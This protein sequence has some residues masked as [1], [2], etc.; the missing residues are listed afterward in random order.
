MK[1]D[2]FNLLVFCVAATLLQSCAIFDYD[3]ADVPNATIQGAIVDS[4][5]N[6]I[7]IECNGGGARIRLYDYGFSS[8]PLPI[9]LR[10]KE[11]G[12]FINTKMF[13]STYN[14]VAEGPFVP[15]IQ[16]DEESN[17]I[18]DNSKKNITSREFG[19]LIFEVEPY[20][21]LEWLGEPVVNENGSVT[22]K[23]KIKRGTNNVAYHKPIKDVLLF[24]N[25]VKYVGNSNYDKYAS[26]KISGTNATSLLNNEVNEMTTLIDPAHP[27]ERGRPYYITV[28]GS[29]DFTGIWGGNLYNYTTIKKVVIPKTNQ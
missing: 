15:L 29:L 28:G 8:N 2:I 13:A 21:K 16:V 7:Q 10:V 25:T 6:N 3:N 1:K 5:G 14:I 27:L 19:N 23:F 26:A 4:D 22:V 9:D 11:D 17:I 20:L 12:T 18:V 24:V